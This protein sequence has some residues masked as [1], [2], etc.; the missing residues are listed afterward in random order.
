MIVQIKANKQMI[1]CL[2]F[3]S[4]ILFANK[5]FAKEKNSPNDAFVEFVKSVQK[6]EVDKSFIL[7]YSTVRAADKMFTHEIAASQ[8]KYSENFKQNP[9]ICPEYL[10]QTVPCDRPSVGRNPVI[11]VLLFFPKT[12]GFSISEVVYADD[13]NTAKMLVKVAYPTQNHPVY[14]DNLRYGKVLSAG[15][16]TLPCAFPDKNGVLTPDNILLSQTVCN[17]GNSTYEFIYDR[18][19][20][21]TADLTVHMAKFKNTWAVDRINFSE[22]RFT[23]SRTGSNN[24][25]KHPAQP[26]QSKNIVTNQENIRVAEP[27]ISAEAKAAA[28]AK[29]AGREWCKDNGDGTVTDPITGLM[30]AAENNGGETSW[31][32]AKLYCENYKVGG[33]TDWRMPTQDELASLYIKA[34]KYQK[35]PALITLKGSFLSGNGRIWASDVRG[36]E[37]ALFDFNNGDRRWARSSGGYA[38]QALPV[39]GVKSEKVE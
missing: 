15:G 13:N 37:A 18:K 3:L 16:L 26:D 14:V 5:S 27:K 24:L 36:S 29:A 23:F 7:D 6:G 17:G 2:L 21:K 10:Y 1:I 20:I 33:Y 9:S 12:S 4:L 32:D 34:G 22:D 35:Y 11:D 39:R 19:D 30:W 38:I 31:P 28:D 25:S 8:S